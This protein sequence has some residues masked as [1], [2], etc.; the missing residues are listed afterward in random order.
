MKFYRRLQGIYRSIYR[1]MSRVVFR[2]FKGGKMVG[3]GR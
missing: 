2:G 3:K 1:R